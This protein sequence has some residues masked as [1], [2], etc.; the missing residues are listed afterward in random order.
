MRAHLGLVLVVL[1]ACGDLPPGPESSIGVSRQALSAPFLVRDLNPVLATASSNPRAF[2]ALSPTRTLFF[3]TTVSEGAELWRTDGTAAGT[4]LVRD[5][6]PGEASSVTGSMVALNGVAYFAATTPQAGTELWRSDGTAPGT[7]LVTDFVPGASGNLTAG[8]VVVG[9]RVLYVSAT[10]TGAYQLAA[11]DGV[12]TSML[13]S[14]SL[15]PTMLVSDGARAYFDALD[16]TFGQRQPWTS[17]GTVSGTHLIAALITSGSQQLSSFTAGGPGAYFVLTGG[18]PNRMQV[19]TTDGTD[20]G[21]QVVKD[22]TGGTT[23]AITAHRAEGPRLYF[24]ARAGPSTTTLWAMD[25]VDAGRSLGTVAFAPPAALPPDRL[26]FTGTDTEPWVTDASDAGTFRLADLSPA[27][28]TTSSEFA[29]SA[30]HVWFTANGGAWVTDGTSPGTVQ[31]AGSGLTAPSLYLEGHGALTFFRATGAGVV[32]VEPWVSDG[33][34]VGTRMLADVAPARSASNPG[35]LAALGPR[36][37]FSA[38]EPTTGVEV[39]ST[40]GTGA[41]T[42]LVQDLVP[43]SG[44]GAPGRFD[45]AQGWAYFTANDATFQSKLHR[46]DGSDA[47]IQPLGV[48]ASALT[49]TAGTPVGFFATVQNGSTYDVRLWT[50]DAGS[51]LLRTFSAPTA[52]A[53]A[54]DT[55]LAIGDTAFFQY[56]GTIYRTNGTAVGTLAVAGGGGPQVTTS[57]SSRASCT[58]PATAGS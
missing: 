16:T 34:A 41:G 5:L 26:V 14:F 45:V 20:A 4:A 1:S 54:P 6:A 57:S 30:G 38:S 53:R 18:S 24:L 11:T 8:P 10:T 44:N 35:N 9:N 32:G 36:V 47:G 28:S 33:T 42:R 2:V 43:G 48:S 21:T 49:A 19:W 58:S 56:A 23:T 7:W 3:A 17:D 51:T 13:K 50:A 22:L 29:S 55:Y 40:D 25:G 46:T 39:W 52:P 12:T 27:G 37:V 15:G 31:L